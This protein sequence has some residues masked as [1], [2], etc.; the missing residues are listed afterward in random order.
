MLNKKC[1]CKES[2]VLTSGPRSGIIKYTYVCVC[3][4]VCM[5]E[6]NAVNA[7]LLQHYLESTFLRCHNVVITTLSQPKSN[8]VT[9]LS[10]R[11]FVCWAHIILVSVSNNFPQRV[12]K[13][14]EPSV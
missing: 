10:Q 3:A 11:E 8:I 9:K 1:N 14:T 13:L 4:C 6:C 7:M 5:C 12:T 2:K